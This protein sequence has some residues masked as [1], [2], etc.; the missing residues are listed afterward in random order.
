VLAGATGAAGDHDAQ[1]DAGLA[2]QSPQTEDE[3]GAGAT[4]TEDETGAAQTSVEVA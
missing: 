1:D 3:T 2:G 4:Q